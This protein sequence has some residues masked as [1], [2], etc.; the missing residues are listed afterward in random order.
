MGRLL[1]ALLFVLLPINTHGYT[2]SKTFYNT[3]ALSAG[4]LSFTTALAVADSG[5]LVSVAVNFSAAPTANETVTLSIASRNGANFNTLLAT[6]TT[7]AGVTTRLTFVV[8][9]V[10]PVG[11]GDQVIVT[12][13]NNSTNA[14]VY[15][16]VLVSQDVRSG[17][18]IAVYRDGTLIATSSDLGAIA[19]L[20][21]TEQQITFAGTG[22]YS[23]TVTGQS[24]ITSTSRIVCQP[25]A[26]SADGQT[27]ET[28]AVAQFDPVVS[29][30]VAGTGFT[31]HVYT[32]VDVTGVF[33]FNC[34]GV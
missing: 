33:R 26:T 17:S 8:G 9:D 31:L 16:S 34:V 15:T 27:V 24:W 25:A 7:V 29:T 30:V 32:P 10:I 6:A 22:Y 23:L 2:P 13:T 21:S 19:G 14:T 4:P 1:L 3:R 18:G 11:T 20:G 28:Y 5:F 12:C